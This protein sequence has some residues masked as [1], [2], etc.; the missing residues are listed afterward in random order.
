MKRVRVIYFASFREDS[1]MAEER[2]F[3]DAATPGELY[4]ELRARHEFAPE[5]EQLRVAVNEHFVAWDTPLNDA[6]EVVF[7]TPFGGG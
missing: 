4:R 6:D 3:T 1:G 2:V 5:P 7:L